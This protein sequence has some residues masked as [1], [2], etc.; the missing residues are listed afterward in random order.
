ML[1][2][3][4]YLLWLIGSL[5]Q[6]IRSLSFVNW[7]WGNLVIRRSQR[8]RSV[9]CWCGL[10]RM[11]ALPDA[12][13]ALWRPLRSAGAWHKFRFAGVALSFPC[14]TR[15]C[16]ACPNP[17]NQSIRSYWHR[18][19]TLFASERTSPGSTGWSLVC[20]FS[21]WALVIYSTRKE[22]LRER[23]H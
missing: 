23:T 18:R 19:S 3:S 6:S 14:R 4:W 16:V 20:W 2:P 17:C 7:W 13:P 12:A 10:R 8:W 11:E 15:S 5:W 9:S 21:V 1:P 22:Y